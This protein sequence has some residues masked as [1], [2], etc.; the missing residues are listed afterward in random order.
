M[1]SKYRKYAGMSHADKSR[2]VASVWLELTVFQRK[3][4]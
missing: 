1:K 4:K 3:G 2:G